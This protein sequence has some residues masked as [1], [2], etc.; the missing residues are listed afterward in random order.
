M[1]QTPAPRKPAV[2]GPEAPSPPSSY[3]RPTY[4]AALD[5]KI[6]HMVN[7]VEPGR[8]ERQLYGCC[9]PTGRYCNRTCE[10][11]DPC[12]EHRVSAFVEYGSGVTAF[13]KNLKV[14]G[15]WAIPRGQ[16][17]GWSARRGVALRAR[18]AATSARL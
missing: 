7:F 6:E 18:R 1:P 8:T 3:K 13:F 11:C 12:C 4:A 10:A 9:V 16:G 5:Y 17:S 15:E 14:L 2:R